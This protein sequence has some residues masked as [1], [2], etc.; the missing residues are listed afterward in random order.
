MYVKLMPMEIKAVVCFGSA[1]LQV[2][3]SLLAYSKT[4]FVK[5]ISDKKY[6]FYHYKNEKPIVNEI[7]ALQCFGRA[8][9]PLSKL[10]VELCENNLVK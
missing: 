1:L 6:V 2:S 5:C 10:P 3:K 9:K 7:Y 8:K 4:N